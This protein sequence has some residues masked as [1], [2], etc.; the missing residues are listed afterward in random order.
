MRIVTRIVDWIATPY[1]LYLLIRDPD[2]PRKA[3]IKAALILLG[4]AFYILNPMD[5]IPEITPVIGWLDD[6]LII[7]AVMALADKVVPEA[8]IAGI[9]QKARS[10]TKRAMLGT[11][12][13]IISIV[14]FSLASIGLLVYLAIKI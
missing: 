11:V 7:P 10:T 14:L 3:K 1:R 2:I 4:V 5:L 6:L 9:R 13:L 8:N 12:A